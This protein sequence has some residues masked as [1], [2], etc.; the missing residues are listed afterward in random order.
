MHGLSA[1]GFVLG[2]PLGL[3][4]DRR[5]DL[6]SC[7]VDNCRS[8][9]RGHRRAIFGQDLER[10]PCV[11]V[12][13]EGNRVSHGN[14]VRHLVGH[15]TLRVGD[16][17]RVG[18][19]RNN[20]RLEDSPRYVF[21]AGGIG[22]TPILPMIEAAKTAGAEWELHYGGRTA[23][24]MAFHDE[25]SAYG[26]RVHFTPQ[27][28]Y[29]HLDLA[30]IFA[31]VT[32]DTLVYA[33]GPEPLLTALEG[34]LAHWP[35]GTLHTERFAPRT[36]TRKRP[37]VEFDVEFAL[38]GV[39][40]TVPA[41]TPILRVAEESGVT[42]LA[43]CREGTCETRI[44]SGEVDHRDSILTPSEQAANNTMMICVSRAAENCRKLVLE[45]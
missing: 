6:P 4:P 11:F 7:G 20:F 18:W 15:D 5:A 9:S 33:C 38:S 28:Q 43:S 30:G 22:I 24:S 35:E 8:N 44:I 27:D 42:V 21:V 37:E 29:G 40:A 19:P 45:A 34:A 32:P 10:P 2:Y 41:G 12:R 31:D 13:P 16:S 26:D 36:I 39:T 17:L 3:G 23:Q 25:L 1:V 14:S